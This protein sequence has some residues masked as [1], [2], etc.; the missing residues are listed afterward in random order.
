MAVSCLPTVLGWLLIT[1]AHNNL[2]IFA[3]RWEIVAIALSYKEERPK[4]EILFRVIYI[5]IWNMCWLD[6]RMSSIVTKGNPF[7]WQDSELR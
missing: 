5:V 6:G 7:T 3:G 2:I 4:S 1:F